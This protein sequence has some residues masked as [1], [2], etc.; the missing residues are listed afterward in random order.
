M[1]SLFLQAKSSL[2]PKWYFLYKVVNHL[3]VQ[4]PLKLALKLSNLFFFPGKIFPNRLEIT[5]VS[6]RR[7]SPWGACPSSTR[8]RCRP[9]RCS[10]QSSRLQNNLLVF[11]HCEHWCYYGWLSNYSYYCQPAQ[12]SIQSSC[13]DND[14][15]AYKLSSSLV[16]I[17]ELMP[18]GSSK[19][20]WQCLS[21]GKSLVTKGINIFTFF[22]EYLGE[23]VCVKA[24]RDQSLH[25]H[26]QDQWSK[27]M[28]R[29][30]VDEIRNQIEIMTCK[31]LWFCCN[32]SQEP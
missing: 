29:N 28:K 31:S 5:W 2:Y 6:R 3:R 22:G 1:K 12:L 30:M 26:L 11:K 20:G 24:L 7:P 14:S 13:L 10:T 9:A 32:R 8:W 17:C 15:S 19:W 21:Q 18:P 16:R 27:M 25:I 4:L 23:E